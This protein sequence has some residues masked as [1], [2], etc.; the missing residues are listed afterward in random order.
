MQKM[1]TFPSKPRVALAAAALALMLTQTA[2]EEPQPSGTAASGETADN[3]SAMTANQ[4]AT[5]NVAAATTSTPATPDY[6]ANAAL[7]DMYEIES[8]KIAKAK[9]RSAA[10]KSFA[11]QMIAD[12]SATTARLK[13]TLPK[14][15]VAVTPP[16]KLD[17]R[18]Q[19]LVD[20][21]QA[22]TPEGF[23]EL[24]RQQ[25]IAAHQ[26]ALQLHQSY[27][28][29]GDNPAL[30]Q[31]AGEITPKVQAHLDMLKGMTP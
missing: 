5:E 28:R 26:E 18:R 25:Q 7:S 16:A 12:H 22:T 4:S 14:T 29:S 9:A 10:I 23:D 27:A 13:E 1:P 31:L 20:Q 8:S 2:C 21:L 6:V 19:A 17:A 11:D 15:G 3:A 30:A 24:Y